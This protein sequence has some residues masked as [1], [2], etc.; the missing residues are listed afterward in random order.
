MTELAT[1]A[2]PYAE[3][4]FKHA[5][6]THTAQQ[7][8]DNLKFLAIAMEEQK[9]VSLAENP[10]VAKSSLVDF[11]LDVGSGYLSRE[12]GNFVRLLVENN[13]L[14]LV[15]RIHSFYES[16]RAEDEGFIEAELKTAFPLSPEAEQNLA[17][18]L[19][20][21]LKRKVLFKIEEDPSLIGGLV[22][23][24]G[25]TVIDASVQGHLQKL[26]KQLYIV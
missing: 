1:L 24:A 25:D 11:L 18:S 3:A 4:V 16:Y 20:N 10:K 2:R 17:K 26:A 19:E 8:S 23:R 21:L 5:K 14:N 9:L 12:G 22:I 6:E 15:S 13:R 7:W